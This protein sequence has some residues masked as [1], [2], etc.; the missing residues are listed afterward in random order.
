MFILYVGLFAAIFAGVLA[1]RERIRNPHS[2]SQS[3]QRM[4][5]MFK[6][7]EALEVAQANFWRD[8]IPAY[9]ICVVFTILYILFSK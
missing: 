7:R 5:L 2:K 9:V 3:K 4:G 6:D 8:R 1:I